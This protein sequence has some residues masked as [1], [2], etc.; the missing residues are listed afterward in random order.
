MDKTKGKIHKG[1]IVFI[2]IILILVIFFFNKNSES[3]VLDFINLFKGGEKTLVLTNSFENDSIIDISLHKDTIIL[4]K[5]NK[6]SFIKKDGELV[7][8]KYFHFL[9][10]AIYF[11]E[12]YIYP[13]DRLTG[14][15]YFF[16]KKGEEN[17][18]LPLGNEVF[19]IKEIKGYLLSHSKA[20]SMEKIHILDKDWVLV[21]NPSFEDKNILSYDIDKKGKNIIVSVLNLNDNILKSEMHHYGEN[22]ENLGFLTIEEEIILFN[23]IIKNDSQ[24]VL[25]DKTLYYVE[26]KEI[27]WE[28]SFNLIKDIYIRKDIIYILHGNYLKAID[29]KGEIKNEIGFTKDYDNIMDFNGRVLL[30]G[31]ENLAIVKDGEVIGEIE[32]PILK[33]YTNGRDIILLGPESLNIY[34]LRNKEENID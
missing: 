8:E 30:Y 29:L 17:Y 2:A 33:A 15:I 18:K 6:L 28:K 34:E 32:E 11:G 7:L 12:E 23:E 4:W 10:P 3:K 21:G 25:T 1:F 9:D 14:N 31:D 16:N 27:I 5:D 20:G 13:F 22:N 24:V 26:N 19:N